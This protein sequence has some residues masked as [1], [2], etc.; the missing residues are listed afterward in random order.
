MGTR[1]IAGE[2]VVV[3]DEMATKVERRSDTFVIDW[4]GPERNAH[5]AT[6][7]SARSEQEPVRFY[8][9]G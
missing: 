3:D 1:I 7:A 5:A 4:A 2:G 9:D 6:G 8:D